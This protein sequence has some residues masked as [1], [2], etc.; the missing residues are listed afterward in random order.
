MF[1]ALVIPG[2]EHSGLELNIHM[3]LLIEEL[4]QLW[5][6]EENTYD[7]YSY[8]QYMICWPMAFGAPGV[9]MVRLGA[10]VNFFQRYEQGFISV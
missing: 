1:L 2:L 5:I 9:Y 10:R 8:G 3:W 7:N 4:K 6:G